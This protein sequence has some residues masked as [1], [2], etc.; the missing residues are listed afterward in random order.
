MQEGFPKET[1][2]TVNQQPHSLGKYV[3]ALWTPGQALE[4]GSRGT[5]HLL[6]EEVRKQINYNVEE[7]RSNSTRKSINQRWPY[8]P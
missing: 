1:R 3:L 6:Q 7:E 2:N 4:E 5:P 8:Q